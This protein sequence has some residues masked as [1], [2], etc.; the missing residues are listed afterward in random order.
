MALPFRRRILYALIALGTVPAAIAVIGWAL[1]VRSPASPAET[2]RQAVAEVAAT[3]RALVQTIDSTRLSRGEREALAQHTRA[4]NEALSRVQRSETLAAYY[5]PTLAAIILGLG[6]LVLYLSVRLGG[7]LSR[8]LTKPIDELVQWTGLIQRE[9]PLPAEPR[10]GGAPEFAALRGAFREMARGLAEARTRQLEAERLRAFRE[11][12]RRVAHEMKNPLTPIRFAVSAL[13][14]S[15][16]P[17]QQESLEVLQAES[18]RLEQLA[19]EFT[20]MGRLTE[21]PASEVDLGEL[22]AELV[23][24]SLPRGVRTTLTLD[25]TT[26]R[27]TGHYEPLR[28]AFGNLLRNAV[29]AATGPLVLEV[30]CAPLGPDGAEVRIVDHG[31]GV[32]P[33]LR[34]TLF[35]AYVTGGKEGGQ[36]LGLALVRQ[37]VEAHGGRIRLEDT[38]G[39]GATFVVTLPVRRPR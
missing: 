15:A 17:E 8:Q 25:P 9:E 6:A 26:P 7:Y 18:A 29:E 2:T 11:V 38:P 1:T 14:R 16:R 3:G 10:E 21:G 30:S 34:E 20:E 33:A 12:A 27:I 35:D 23:R 36:G 13:A 37:T 31:P 39:G 19:R 22:V 5:A 28:R 4:L 24:T 32:A